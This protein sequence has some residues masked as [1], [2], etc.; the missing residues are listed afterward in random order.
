M[1]KENPL[2]KLSTLV[3]GTSQPPG[4][5]HDADADDGPIEEDEKKLLE[6]AGAVLKFARQRVGKDSDIFDLQILIEM[7]AELVRDQ[8]REEAYDED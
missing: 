8:I 1:A 6:D 2:D 5:R 3:G 4:A 7:C